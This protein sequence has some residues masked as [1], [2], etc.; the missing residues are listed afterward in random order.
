MKK[1]KIG[2][3][4][5]IVLLIALLILFGVGFYLLWSTMQKGNTTEPGP[6]VVV[7]EK[8]DR[9]DIAIFQIG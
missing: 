6:T 4:L 3:I 7:E 2:M 9:K 5:I 8:L 1:N